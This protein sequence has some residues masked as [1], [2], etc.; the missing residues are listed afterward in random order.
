MST[1]FLVST[2][3]E[4]ISAAHTESAIENGRYICI[5]I[6]IHIYIYLYIYTYISAA[7]SESAIKNDR[8]CGGTGWGPFR[9]GGTK[10]KK[11]KTINRYRIL[12]ICIPIYV[13]LYMYIYMYIYVCIFVSI[14]NLLILGENFSKRAKRLIGIELYSCVYV[15]MYVF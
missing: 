1:S 10:S 3:N 9:F 15:Y 2:I 4:Y 8:R 12:S 5:Y 13:Y 7:H 11:S 14:Y 6:Y